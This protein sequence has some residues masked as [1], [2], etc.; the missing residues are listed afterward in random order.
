[1]RGRK[2]GCIPW[3]KGLTKESDTRVSVYSERLKDQFK[4]GRR[5]WCEG[6]TKETNASILS[7]SYKLKGKATWN[8]GL[9]KETDSRVLKSAESNSKAKKKLFAE[10]KL[11]NWMKGLTKET[12]ARVAAAAKNMSAGKIGHACTNPTGKGKCGIRVDLNQFFRSRYEAN[13]ARILNY[14]GIEW[15]Y[16]VFRFKFNDC[17]YLPDFYLPQFDIWI[18]AKGWLNSEGRTKLYRMAEFYPNEV[19]KILDGEAYRKISKIYSE[20]IP[21]WEK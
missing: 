14:L 21:S 18:E 19:I 7:Q 17:S 11:K 3:N 6:L 10:G 1:M 2:K 13:F 16:E 4:N 5:T 12:D 20:I 9:T 15:E 8:S